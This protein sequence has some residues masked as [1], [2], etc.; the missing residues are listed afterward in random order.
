MKLTA[1]FLLLL[2]GVP[3][4]ILVVTSTITFN[5][6]KNTIKKEIL[7]QQQYLLNDV[8]NGVYG[9]LQQLNQKVKNIAILP[10]SEQMLTGAPTI[11]YNRDEFN[12]HPAY[13]EYL[14]TI[15]RFIDSNVS[16]AYLVS[17]ETGALI[18]NRWIELPE[19]YD[20][21]VKDYYKNPVIKNG[22]AL[23]EPYMNA[24]GTDDPTAITISYPVKSENRL[25]GV[26][27]ID[28]GLAGIVEYISEENRKYNASISIYTDQGNYIYSPD[29]KDMTR[30]IN[31]YEL[32]DSLG[33][34]DVDTVL[35]NILS[36]KSHNF[37]VVHSADGSV[38]LGFTAPIKD[39]NW[40]VSV[41]YP[42]KDISAK[43]TAS[44]L[45]I[46]IL[47]AVVLLL[48][49]AAVAIILNITVIRNILT[50][51]GYLKTI[52]SG[53]LVIDID[54][55]ILSRND[56][57]GTLGQ[58][59]DDMTRN[60]QD[61]VGKVTDAANYISSG[62]NQVSDSSQMLSNGAT[63]QAAS[64]EEVSSS[65]EQMSANISQNADNSSQT[66]KIAIK[67]AR[68]A[69]ESGETVSE[70]VEAMG[71]IANKITIIEEISR[72]TN[73]LALNAAIEA[74]RAGEH[75]K[76][77]AVVATEVR[78]LAEQSQKAAGEI[79]EL[80]S[81]TVE[82][83]QGSGEKLSKL[84]P[85]IERTAELVEEISAAS[86]EQQSGVDQITTAIHQ[87]DKIIQSNASSSEE[88]A[89]TSEELAA[90]A[91]QLKATIQYFKINRDRDSGKM[92]QLHQ[93]PRRSTIKNEPVKS[94]PK[95]TDKKEENKPVNNQRP[96]SSA[97]GETGI[98]I[99][100]GSRK[101]ETEKI[102]D[103]DFESF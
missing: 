86:N 70:A 48:T 96:P 51:S 87:L 27:A 4:I 37:K 89:S 103:D 75:G 23:S 69:R 3:L 88:L 59:L 38:D 44:V 1:K 19:R 7:S 72:S 22:L 55:K 95:Q 50:T 18:I 94:A 25:L 85:D 8:A 61:I 24:E 29:I 98:T 54:P 66:E 65:M 47:S 101:R 40:I 68:D 52:S 100:S 81:R 63:E 77:F 31:L 16:L 2:I 84:V 20:G 11:D 99:S 97:S 41:F 93:P 56:E 53:D 39:T 36:G 76:G 83:S 82:L 62:A 45:P 14:D 79:T 15:N 91:E 73:L 9:E 26:A 10:I 46:T 6:Q 67:A 28:I 21:R 42:E 102:Y 71:L 57:I 32:K 43:I 78:K 17:E 60:L 33:L 12:S 5:I 58:S 90:Q 30:I 13:E 35:E 49:L 74:A 92:H 80:A 64:A 34:E